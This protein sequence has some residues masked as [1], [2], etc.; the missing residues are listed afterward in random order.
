MRLSAYNSTAT[1]TYTLTETPIGGPYQ[2]V[3]DNY[4]LPLTTDTSQGLRLTL[5]SGTDTYRPMVYTSASG[6]TYDSYYTSSIDP[7]NMSSTTALTRSSTSG[8]TVTTEAAT[9]GI[10]AYTAAATTGVTATTEAA[11]TGIT[12][13]TAAATTGA[14]AYTAASEST[15]QTTTPYNTTTEVDYNTYTNTT[16]VTVYDTITATTAL[17]N[18]VET[19]ITNQVAT[20]FYTHVSHSSMTMHIATNYTA[21][22]TAIIDGYHEP[23]YYN[24]LQ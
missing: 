15:W 17:T 2:H 1:T 19:L 20:T 18:T 23:E 14:T 6:S 11:T 12:A 4:Y 13:T 5:Q 3:N 9:T 22:T 10:T 16:T 7:G 8:I 21:R 24:T